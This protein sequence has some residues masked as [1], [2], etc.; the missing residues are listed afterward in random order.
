MF[1]SPTASC[2][3]LTSKAKN[4]ILCII[5]KLRMLNNNIFGV[6]F[7]G[8]FLFYF[9]LFLCAPYRTQWR[10]AMARS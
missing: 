3:D 9:I 5:Q 6:C 1:S 4:A 7:L 10:G 2:Y 8:L